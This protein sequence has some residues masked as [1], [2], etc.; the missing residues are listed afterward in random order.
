MPLPGISS[1]LWKEGMPRFRSLW[2]SDLAA[3]SVET[4]LTWTT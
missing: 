2:V 4:E 3:A 1:A